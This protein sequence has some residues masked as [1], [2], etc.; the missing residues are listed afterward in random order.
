MEEDSFSVF[1]KAGS[2]GD[3]SLTLDSKHYY[4]LAVFINTKISPVI[5][6][7]ESLLKHEENIRNMGKYKMYNR[8]VAFIIPSSKKNYSFL[9]F[10]NEKDGFLTCS[11]YSDG[12]ENIIEK[13]GKK[14]DSLRKEVDKY[15]F[16]IKSKKNDIQNKVENKDDEYFITNIPVCLEEEIKEKIQEYILKKGKKLVS[17]S[18]YY[19]RRFKNDGSEKIV[20]C[21]SFIINSGKTKNSN[22]FDPN[23]MIDE[24]DLTEYEIFNHLK[25]FVS[26]KSDIFE[27]ACAVKIPMTKS[28]NKMIKEK[29]DEEFL[30]NIAFLLPSTK[31]YLLNNADWVTAFFEDDIERKDKSFLIKLE[32]LKFKYINPNSSMESD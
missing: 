22:D 19:P 3:Y 11:I 7:S 23:K 17:F 1:E 13:A 5:V 20:S 31:Y 30:T 24:I 25:P 32:K 14:A 21:Y 26:E 28:A 10:I 18:M 12:L 4:Q 9:R 16:E 8:C 27:S 6:F 15:S 2:N 29:T